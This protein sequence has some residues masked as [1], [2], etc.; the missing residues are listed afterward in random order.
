VKQHKLAKELEYAQAQAERESRTI[1]NHDRI[2]L[3]AQHK[4]A[5]E[6]ISWRSRSLDSFE[7]RRK[8]DQQYRQVARAEMRRKERMVGIGPDDP[9][10]I[11]SSNSLYE[12]GA[13]CQNFKRTHCCND[14]VAHQDKWLRKYLQ[15]DYHRMDPPYGGITRTAGGAFP[16]PS[17]EATYPSSRMA[18]EMSLSSPSL[19][20]QSCR[21]PGPLPGQSIQRHHVMLT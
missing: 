11:D 7:H 8:H 6:N 21:V 20:H 5:L 4:V 14:L 9:R 2:R 18:V 15:W 10:E 3:A 17:G 1:A 12:G 19:L 13:G 16:L